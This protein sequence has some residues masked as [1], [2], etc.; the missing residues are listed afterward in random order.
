MHAAKGRSLAVLEFGVSVTRTPRSF[1]RCVPK[2]TVMAKSRM[3]VSREL[4]LIFVLLQELGKIA[5]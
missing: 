4:R 2:A 1:A 3:R 5:G